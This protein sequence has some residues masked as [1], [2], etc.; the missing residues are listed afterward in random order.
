M[1]RSKKKQNDGFY[2]SFARNLRRL[3][4]ENR[5][6]Q[7]ELAEEI[8]KSRQTVSQYANGIN[9]P[10]YETLCKI[11]SYFR[12]TTDYILGRTD[13]K[14]PSTDLQAVVGYTGLTEDNVVAL[15]M[16][17]IV[18]DPRDDFSYNEK[19]TIKGDI[20]YL[21]LANDLLDALYENRE[22]LVAMYYLL[23]REGLQSSEFDVDYCE[24]YDKEAIKHGCTLIP[25]DVAVK[26]YC[27][28]LGGAIER[29]FEK[30]Y[31]ESVAT[32]T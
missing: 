9:E 28:R 13:V 6:S 7:A 18:I 2:S 4:D 17:K 31:L 21:D 3:M 32:N 16:A 30:K 26:L 14:M 24:Q 5:V 10:G 8:A 22:F 11:A 29:Y 23:R 27:T 20:P 1:E 15:N 25:T 19:R 12:V